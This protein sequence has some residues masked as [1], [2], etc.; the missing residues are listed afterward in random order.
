MTLTERF[1]VRSRL[2][3]VAFA[4]PMNTA[5]RKRAFDAIEAFDKADIDMCALRLFMDS[6]YAQL[7]AANNEHGHYE[8][9]CRAFSDQ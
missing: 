3:D 7:I 9:Y 5:V 2:C 8:T 4:A 1:I 6:V